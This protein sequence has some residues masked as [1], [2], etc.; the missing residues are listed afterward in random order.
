MLGG[1]CVSKQSYKVRQ[2]A[3]E[4]KSDRSMPGHL[5]ASPSQGESETLLAPLTRRPCVLYTAQ[6]SAALS[7]QA[8]PWQHLHQPEA[9]ASRKVHGGIVAI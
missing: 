7:F 2:N 5:L 3:Q 1:F 8:L 6:A 4:V 9:H